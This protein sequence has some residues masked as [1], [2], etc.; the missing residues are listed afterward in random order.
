MKKE[1]TTKAQ[2][3]RAFRAIVKRYL[4][5]EVELDK[6]GDE[7]DRIQDIARMNGWKL[8]KSVLTNPFAQK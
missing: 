2:C 7:H 4:R 8:P 5:A 1:I 6:A 3:V